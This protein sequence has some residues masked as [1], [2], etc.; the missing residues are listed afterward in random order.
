MRQPLEDGIVTI[1]RA[2][3]TASFPSRFQLVCAMNPC[4]C[5][6]YGHPSGRCICTEQSVRNYHSK[7]SGP[8]LDRIDLIIEV[9]SLDFCE[10]RMDTPGESSAQIKQRVEAARALQRE[11]FAGGTCSC[12]A[13][14]QTAELRE[15][16]ELSEDCA[17]LMR[18][19]FDTLGM[20][21]RSYDRV[22]KVARTIADLEGSVEI[23][24]QH[25][26]EAVQ[27]RSYQLSQR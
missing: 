19:A 24:P 12:N 17:E 8:L 27:Y 16:C 6:W 18:A 5:G 13:Y 1:T 23:Q 21:A 7:I 25:I 4:R 26:A 10:L 2:S 9:P 3:S 11:R 15:F 20:T 14:M 22:R